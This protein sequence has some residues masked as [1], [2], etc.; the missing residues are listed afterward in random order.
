MV[1]AVPDWAKAE[2]P[3]APTPPEP[4]PAPQAEA[5]PD[6]AAASAQPVTAKSTAVEPEMPSF[7]TALAQGIG[8]GI[9]HAGESIRVMRGLQPES[10]IAE[11]PAAAPLEWSDIYSPV[12]QLAPKL[13]YGLGESAPTLAGGIMGGIAGGIT[14]VPGGALLGGAAGAGLGAALQSVGPFFSEELKRSPSDP[15]G[16]WTRAMERAGTSG[17]FSALGWGLFP[18]RLSEG[19]LKQMAFQAFGVQGPV[20]AAQQA[21]QNVIQGRPPEEGLGQAYTQGAVGTAVPMAGHAILGAALGEKQSIN[22]ARAGDPILSRLGEPSENSK[23]WMT[24]LNH[25]YTAVKD[26][27]HPWLEAENYLADGTEIAPDKSPYIAARLTRGSYGVA[28]HIL[29]YGMLDPVTKEKTGAPG[30]KQVLEPVMD[31]MDGFRKYMMSRRAIELDGRGIETGIPIRDAVDFVR[32]NQRFAKP[33]QGWTN[34][35]HG[36][37][38]YMV[39]AGIV[40][41]EDAARMMDANK[42]YT[43]FYRLMEDPQSYFGAPG[44]GL[45]VRNPIRG[46][47]GSER[48]ILDPIESTIKNTYLY[49]ALA[50]RNMAL[51]KLEALK[52]QSP[53]GDDIMVKVRPDVHPIQV[54]PE[55]V[56]AALRRQPVTYTGDPEAFTIFRP[57]AFRPEPDKIRVFNDGKPTTYKV[58]PYFGASVNGMDREGINNLTKLLAAPAKL[59]RAGATLSPEFIARNPIRDQFSAFVFSTMGRGY[60]PFYDLML[61][62]G[63]VLKQGEGYQKW[64]ASGGANSAM[65][66]IDRDYIANLVRKMSDPSITGTIKNIAKSP[67]DL[68]RAASE[69][70]ENATRVGE[71]MRLLKRG[72]S[73]AEAGYGSREVTLDFQRIGSKMRAVNQIIAFFN[74]QVEGVDRAARA[75][76]DHPYRFAG[77]VGAGIMLPSMYLW[78]ANRSD[79]RVQEIPR[80]EKDLFWI[81]PTDNWQNVTAQD[82]ARV[83]KGYARQQDGQWQ[84]NKGNIYRIPKPFELGVLF[85]SVPERILDAWA[86]KNPDAFKNVMSSVGQ[87]FLPN[88]VPNAAS[89]V[90]EQF[91]NRSLFTER[92]LVPQYLEGLMPKYRANP[93][94]TDTAKAIASFISQIP[95]LPES[96][97]SPIVVE[98]YIRAWTGGLGLHALALSDGILRGAGVA[99]TRIEPKLTNSDKTLIKAF[100]VRFPEAGANSI[101]DFY[102]EYDKRAQAKKTITFLRKAGQK[103][104]AADVARQN[105]LASADGIKKA[106]GVQFKLVRDTYRNP[107]MT[108]E[109][110]RNFIDMSYLQLIKMAQTGNEMFKKTDEQFRAKQNQ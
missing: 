59:L 9:R 38:D 71:N 60:V 41:K 10:S 77:T 65:V 69:V 57:N 61:G 97:G 99:P 31:D 75:M 46:M 62:M 22:N 34:F 6:W 12:S 2:T 18:A 14:P 43:P 33:F 21:T 83:P 94:T 29:E 15:D 47:T 102:E 17:A 90:I 78:S 20:A 107:K 109:E 103:E 11:S 100:A 72:A 96:T 35:Q 87:A 27:L 104:E 106:M 73:M 42:D 67:L 19:P 7:G 37:L 4:A 1:D 110:K 54:T 49:V 63:Q 32:Q 30:L 24:K 36:L 55:E 25:L 80:W 58:D 98:N 23:G 88:F 85:G 79:P 89:P 92:P 70:M 66:S 40:G 48:Q 108:P 105:A 64:L 91:A 76:W 101:Q 84:I 5:A 45:K 52:K 93:Y 82:A 26:D 74:A 95:G 51:Q 13:A 53:R 50:D 16:A 56:E 39:K 81:L 3:P 28:E 68:L 86:G 8:A 44:A